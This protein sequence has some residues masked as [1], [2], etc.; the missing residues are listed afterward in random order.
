MNVVTQRARMMVLYDGDHEVEET[1]TRLLYKTVLQYTG[2]FDGHLTQIYNGRLKLDTGDERWTHPDA[3]GSYWTS[4]KA[5]RKA[6]KEEYQGLLYSKI[7]HTDTRLTIKKVGKILTDVES[8]IWRIENTAEWEDH[9]KYRHYGPELFDCS[10]WDE[11]GPH[12]WPGQSGG[13]YWP[14]NYRWVFAYVVHGGSEGY[15]LHVDVLGTEEKENS[16]DRKPFHKHLLMAKSLGSEWE[17]C[18]ES[19][20][21]ISYMLQ[22]EI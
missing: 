17:R 4:D 22:W 15:W 16:F 11:G 5:I 2:D 8:A 12:A 13:A 20:A 19:A 10:Y 9:A 3:P 18:Y 6:M 21:R 14:T 7:K 1:A